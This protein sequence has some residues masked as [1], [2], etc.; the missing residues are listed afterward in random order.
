MTWNTLFF[1]A[2]VA[3]CPLM[4]VWMMRGGGQATHDATP[5]NMV[6]D[7]DH[8]IADLEREVATLRAQRSEPVHV[9]DMSRDRP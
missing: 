1:L 5:T 6:G 9:I 2:L 7:R 4:M 8:R 3:S